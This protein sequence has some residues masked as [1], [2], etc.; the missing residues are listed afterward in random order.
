MEFDHMWRHGYEYKQ[1]EINFIKI[2]R[3]AFLMKKNEFVIELQISSENS[4]MEEKNE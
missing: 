4:K 2:M 1:K 3:E